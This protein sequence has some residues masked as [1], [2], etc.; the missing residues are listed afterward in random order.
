[1]HKFLRSTFLV[2][3]LA[4]GV[5]S[6]LTFADE[7][8]S[9]LQEVP[10]PNLEGLESAVA[11]QLIAAQESLVAVTTQKDLPPQE[12]G[13][14]FG[15]MGQLYHA[16]QLFTPAEACYRNAHT[17][18]PGDFRWSYLLA[19]VLQREGKPELAIAAYERACQL[20]STSVACLTNLGKLYSESNRVDEAK[21]MLSRALA[22]DPQSAA[23]HDG[24]G[25]VALAQTQYQEAVQH[26]EAALT[27]A[28]AANRLH[29]ALAMAYRQLHEPEKAE[30]HL[31]RMGT[32]GVKVADPLI[33]Q[34]EGLVQGERLAIL[35]GRLAFQAGH[36][37]EA[38]S[39][40]KKAVE[41]APQSAIARINLGVALV[42]LGQKDEAIAQLREAL[43]LQPDNE[44][45]HYNLALLL[46]QQQQRDEA[47]RHLRAA[48]V[49]N[50]ADRQAHLQL[51]DALRE[52]GRQAEALPHYMKAAELDP[53]DEIALRWTAE[54][55][56]RLGHFNEARK[57][58]EEAHQR[59]P[60]RGRTAHA[61]ARLLAACPDPTVRDGKRALELGQLVYTA[62]PSPQHAETVALAL[63]EVGNCQEASEWQRRLVET[64]EKTGNDNLIQRLKVDLARYEQGGVCRP[65]IEDKPSAATQ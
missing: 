19:D 18:L 51:G 65:L 10:F 33:E 64:A 1:M 59:F 45:A 35:R 46:L 23:V 60:E 21:T 37:A 20:E 30:A 4:V 44:T 14:A 2:V 39:E 63:A 7:A 47:I 34:I 12:L 15:I 8:P 25:R 13:E 32:V 56:V 29:Y 41:A 24:L 49:A 17:L 53:H 22:L 36:A 27:L 54:L 26:F 28:P 11:A 43:R 6:S 16:Y 55:L 58:L 52:L 62:E 5:L 31:S 9:N 38:A 57:R 50:P 61:L 3:L 48:L 40:F 42:Q